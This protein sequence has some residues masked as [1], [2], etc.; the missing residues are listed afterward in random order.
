MVIDFSLS[1]E[2]WMAMFQ[3]LIDIVTD[4]FEKLGI[5][6]FSDEEAAAPEEET[7]A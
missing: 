1:I 3:R 7:T 6:I 4:F 5:K 2:D